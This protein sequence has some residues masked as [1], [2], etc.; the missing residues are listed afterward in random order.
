MK[1]NGIGVGVSLLVTL[2]ATVACGGDDNEGGGKAGSGNAGSAT[3]AGA[4]GSSSGGSASQGG[5][6]A[7]VG[8]SVGTAGSGT[9]GNG[10]AGNGTGG[11]AGGGDC[12]ALCTKPTIKTCM[13]E[14]CVETCKQA[15][16]QFLAFFPQCSAQWNTQFA[17][18]AK[19]P[20]ENVMCEG[21]IITSP[22]CANEKAALEACG[23]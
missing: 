10:T 9:A 7:G 18:I 8:G 3:H 23:N 12:A 5:S 11:N 21:S 2:G 4:G 17:C 20:N 14:F 16:Q 6:A 22:A 15:E 19:Q 1:L 13:G